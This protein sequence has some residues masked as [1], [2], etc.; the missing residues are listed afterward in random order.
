MPKRKIPIVGVLID[1]RKNADRN[2]DCRPHQPAY[3]ATSAVAVS[4]SHPLFL[5]EPHLAR[6]QIIHAPIATRAK[7]QN[8]NKRN[9][10]SESKKSKFPSRKIIPMMISTIAPV[11]ILCALCVSAVPSAGG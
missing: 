7:G 3:A 1:E 5:L 2:E 6:F 9:R 8:R 4:P 10:Y 11:G